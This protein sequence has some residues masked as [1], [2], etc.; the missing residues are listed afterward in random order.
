MTEEFIFKKHGLENMEQQ[1][2]QQNSSY[3]YQTNTSKA[4]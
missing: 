1:A 4:Y 3:N 2:T